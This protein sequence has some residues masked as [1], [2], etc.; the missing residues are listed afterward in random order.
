MG[1]G[2]AADPGP[3]G[4]AAA[5]D[6]LGAGCAVSVGSVLWAAAACRA[7]SRS[8][9]VIADASGRGA[10]VAAVC[11]ASVD[12]DCG[13]S[14]NRRS[15]IRLLRCASVQTST[16]RARARRRSAVGVVSSSKMSAPRRRAESVAI[17]SS[18]GWSGNQ[19]AASS[20]P[21]R[22]CSVSWMGTTRC[23]GSSKRL[24]SSGAPMC[25][26]HSGGLQSSSTSTQAGERR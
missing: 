13:F 17:A 26:P 6:A 3:R 16:R 21:W 5:A 19:T 25:S 14:E 1:C 23:S 8:S 4:A 7:R 2:V 10:G 11:D 20:A 18:S 15:D 22:S 9:E 12:G 24:S